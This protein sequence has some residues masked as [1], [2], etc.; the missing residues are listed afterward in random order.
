M[1]EVDGEATH[2]IDGV[3]GEVDGEV[4]RLTVNRHRR[5]NRAV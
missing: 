1:H 2:A 4:T 5:I 3:D